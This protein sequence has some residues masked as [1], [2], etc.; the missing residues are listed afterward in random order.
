[1]LT[2]CIYV[3]WI[4]VFWQQKGSSQ[5]WNICCAKCLKKFNP[6]TVQ[7]IYGPVHQTKAKEIS[8]YW[9]C[10]AYSETCPATVVS[11]QK[12]RHAQILY[13]KP[14]P[15][16][17]GMIRCPSITRSIPEERQHRGLGLCHIWKHF[18]PPARPLSNYKITSRLQSSSK[19]LHPMLHYCRKHTAIYSTS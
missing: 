9:E 4:N 13:V 5:D 6:F 15:P 1:M 3:K 10:K 8:M 14:T 7:S 18:T 12:Y 17:R 2:K 16:V 11:L 19:S